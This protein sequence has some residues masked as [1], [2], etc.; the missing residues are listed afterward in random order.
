MFV[1]EQEEYKRENIDWKFI[2]FGLDLQPTIELLE[3]PVGGVFAML[4]EECWFPKAT[5]KTFVEKLFQ[6]CTDSPKLIKPDFKRQREV[7]V[8]FS[9]SHYAGRVD[10]NSN[11]WLTKNMDPLNENVVQLLQASTDQFV[12]LLWKDAGDVVGMSALGDNAGESAFGATRIKRGMFR[13]VSQLYKEQ[14]LKLMETL[15]HTN[16]NFVRCIIPNHEKKVLYISSVYLYLL[17]S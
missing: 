10:Y 7:P 15:N 3:K 11:K 12:A 4:D 17:S 16:P 2:D 13:T 8:D 14:L 1:L 5:D 6:M 9:I